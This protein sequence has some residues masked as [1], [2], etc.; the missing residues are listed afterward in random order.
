LA[1]LNKSDIDRI[2][3]KNYSKIK[4]LIN[5]NLPYGGEVDRMLSLVYIQIID[6][7]S[8][9]KTERDVWNWIINY[10]KKW[11]W[12]GHQY[13]LEDSSGE[14]WDKS[15]VHQLD[16]DYNLGLTSEQ[17][18]Y[19]ESKGFEIDTRM[20][21]LERILKTLPYEYK[22]LFSLIFK[23]GRVSN[24][25]LGEILNTDKHQV[26]FLKR[27]LKAMLKCNP[28]KHWRKK[29]IKSIWENL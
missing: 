1:N 14:H 20:D 16:S 4:N 6:N 19:V 21:E 15:R 24:A 23:E 12:R 28:N 26:M 2:F 17:E 9:I 13:G 5:K 18:E 22:I 8:S 29:E 27:K 25:E 11:W 7:Q 10:T 3:T